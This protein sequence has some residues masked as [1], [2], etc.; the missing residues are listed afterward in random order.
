MTSGRAFI[1]IL[2]D[3]VGYLGDDRFREVMAHA[4][5]DQQFGAGDRVLD[6]FAAGQGDQ[7]IVTAMNDQGRC[8]DLRQP[9]N[10]AVS[11]RDGGQ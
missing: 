11:R 6:V 10:P 1:G 4:V 8:D 2:L 5:D 3:C 9:R 7:R